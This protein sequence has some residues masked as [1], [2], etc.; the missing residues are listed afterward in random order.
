MPGGEEVRIGPFIGGLNTLSDQTSIEDFELVE[1]TNFELDIDGSLVSRPPIATT[2]ITLTLGASGNMKYLGYF[3]TTGGAP[4]LIAS[5]GY[6]STYYFNGTAWT[7][8]TNTISAAAMCQYKDKAWL[9]API[10]SANPGGTWTPGGGF[11]ADANM[12]KGACIIGHK[13]RVWVGLG[14]TATSNGTRLYLSDITGGLPTWPASPNFVD[15]GP[16]DGQNIVDLTTYYS[17]VVIFKQGSTY[18]YAY[19]ADPSTGSISRI[20]DNI[21]AADANCFAA[22]E[23][24]LYVL[25]DNKVYQ[26]TNYNYDRLNLKVPLVAD[27]PAVNLSEYYSISVWS[28]RV[29]VA[30]Y[31]KLFVYSLRTRTWCE[32]QSDSLTNIGRMLPIP[33]QQGTSPTAYTYSTVPRANTLYKIIDGVGTP[34]EDMTCSFLT[35]NFDYQSPSRFKRLW[36]WGADVISKVGISVEARPVT[37]VVSVTWNQL[38]S[39]GYTWDALKNAG[40]TWDRLLSPSIVVADSVSTAG[41]SDGRKFIKFL[42]SLRFRQIAFS[43]SVD[44]DGSSTTA[45]VRVF[46]LITKVRDKAGVGQRIS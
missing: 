32:W 31:D 1:Q 27:N 25:F 34:S 4:Y 41:L 14:K 35:K 40:A 10:G 23:N 46:S 36:W 28:D 30:F 29:F 13:E 20:S 26:F 6:T 17:D 38:N 2:G 37:Y 44:T 24:Q 5:D 42:K 18:R 3:V 45:P 39:G 11:V 22:Y 21:G 43:V 8:I 12:P 7:L 15:I 9:V 16:G 19:D 33:G